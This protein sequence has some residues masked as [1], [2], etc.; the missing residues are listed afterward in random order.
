MA[1]TTRPAVDS[2][3]SSAEAEAPAPTLAE[4]RDAARAEYLRL[5]ELDDHINSSG[6]AARDQAITD[7]YENVATVMSEEA[8]QRRADLDTRLGQIAMPRSST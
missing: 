6:I 3:I 4:Q 8:R 1:T 5:Q 2:R 7:F